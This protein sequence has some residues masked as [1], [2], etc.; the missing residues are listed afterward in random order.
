MVEEDNVVQEFLIESHENLDRLD[1]DLVELERNPGDRGTL[2]RVFRT[3]HTIKGTCG[4]LGFSKLESIAHAGESLL[5]KL[6]DGKLQ[7]S[8]A[9]TS[10]VLSL[11]DAIRQIL[12]NIEERQNEGENA[13]AELVQTLNRLQNTDHADAPAN[14][15]P[16][17]A[18]PAP[19]PTPAASA[20][21]AQAA[22]PPAPTPAP[23]A[24]VAP[25]VAATPTPAVAQPVTRSAAPSETAEPA[26]AAAAGPEPTPTRVTNSLIPIAGRLGDLLVKHGLIPQGELAVALEM[27]RRGDKRRI[28]DILVALG[29]VK[30]SD[31]EDLLKGKDS[32]IV[33]GDKGKAADKTV[34]VDVELLDALMNLLSELVLARNQIL[35]HTTTQRD[36]AFLR[37]TQRLNLVTSELQDR[38]VRTR[39]QPINNVLSRFPRVVRDL[40]VTCGKKVRVEIE[41]KETELDKSL[42]EAIS[43][44]LTHLVRNAVD[45]GVEKPDVRKAAGKNPEGVLLLRAYHESG[46]VNIEITDDGAGIRTERIRQKAL[47]KDLIT[48]AQASKM[49]ERELINLIFLPGFSTA[50]KVTNVSGRGVG[51]DVVKTNIERIGGTVEIQ[52]RVGQGS[53]FR[54][55]IPL[56][57]AI[58][59]ALIVACAGERF[60]IPQVGVAEL[61][62]L[63]G[64]QLK[65]DIQSIK[66]VSVYRLRGQLIPLVHLGTQLELRG[67]RP[68]GGDNGK[69]T[70]AASIVVLQ[71]DNRRFGLVVDK[72]N[73]AQEIVVK[74]LGKE[75]KGMAGFAGATIMGDGR[76]ALIL[77]IQGLAQRAGV[78]AKNEELFAADDVLFSDQGRNDRKT[79]LLVG[80]GG[81]RRAAIP[82]HRVERIERF[83]SKSV[84]WAG[85]HEVIQYRGTV[86]PLVRVAQAIGIGEGADQQTNLRCVVCSHEGRETGLLVDS[87]VDIIVTENA[88]VGCNSD[89]QGVLG[90]AA[91]Q[92]HMTDVLDVNWLS[93]LAPQPLKGELQD[94]PERAAAAAS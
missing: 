27:Q 52:T 17:V 87:I 46:Q 41:G 83:P 35:Q 42:I 40:A 63:K 32:R 49:T 45:H 3:I 18:D 4:F 70:A 25:A 22:P 56:T 81:A 9:I 11:V 15:A 24:T 7:M 84:E 94:Q 58:I 1:Q 29:V 80:L 13:F 50:D 47:E 85:A 92:G 88:P 57:L 72:I 64:E 23:V 38:V 53:T 37:A 51:M 30:E 68:L 90:S 69:N 43:D 21:Q 44:P 91:I 89:R 12:A 74:P 16:A 2:D 8:S 36:P 75:F 82:L 20:T 31:N 61:V 19:A 86:L 62:R 59:P 5:S 60:A 93:G 78:T 10:A 34:R 66:G 73:D 79:Y 71:A 77:D 26:P 76:V 65:T 14:A 54:I 67:A 28:G 55:K 48:Q 33:S 6:R 39:M